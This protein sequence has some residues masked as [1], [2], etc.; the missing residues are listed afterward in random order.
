MFTD[1]R[2]DGPT[3]HLWV[4]FLKIPRRKVSKKN[5]G[6]T[7]VKRKYGSPRG[8]RIPVYALKGRC[9]SP[10]DDGAVKAA[11]RHDAGAI[12]LL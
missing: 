6:S 3:S 1:V 12:D 8:I 7:F 10:L 4:W 11:L 9:P 2:D 5:W